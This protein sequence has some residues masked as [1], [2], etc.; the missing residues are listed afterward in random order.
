MEQTAP[1]RRAA[2]P[3]PETRAA[4]PAARAAGNKAGG[5]VR[6]R[7]S[8]RTRA[9]VLA[10]AT[11]EFAEHGFNGA[12]IERIARI[13][14]ANKQLI[15]YYFGGKEKLYIAVLEDAYAGIRSAEAELHLVDLD[16]VEGVRELALFTW[17]YHIRNP[18]LISLVRTENLHKARF[19]KRSTRIIG[20]NSPLI[21]GVTQLIRRGIASRQFRAD[22][23]PIEVY[24]TIAALAFYYLGNH[25]TLE[26]NFGRELMSRDRLDAWG[27]HIVEVVLCYLRPQTGGKAPPPKSKREK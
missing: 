6:I 19:L 16:P 4:K 8:E 12:R 17:R 22:A 25:W 2:I 9:A 27:Q 23:D 3:R 26:T 5:K 24:F 21:Q 18:N 15:Y 1:R 11:I 10:A 13:A 14:R 20:L 7:D